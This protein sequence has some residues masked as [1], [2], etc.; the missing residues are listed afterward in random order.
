MV[1]TDPRQ[2][3]LRPFTT[4]SDTPRALM[5]TQFRN[6]VEPEL[7]VEYGLGFLILL[8]RLAGRTV[9]HGF[10]G[11]AW[12]DLCT[13]VAMVRIRRPGFCS[14]ASPMK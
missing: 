9:L 7:Y 12:D 2:I 4:R 8:V 10:G 11:L 5:S 6:H 3:G 13:F 1:K 14:A